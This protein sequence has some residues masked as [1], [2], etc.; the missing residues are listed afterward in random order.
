MSTAPKKSGKA[1]VPKRKIAVD[2]EYEVP[3]GLE[4]ERDDE[5][6]ESP[7]EDS[8]AKALFLAKYKQPKQATRTIK[9]GG[10][11]VPTVTV[12][13]V[14][15]R[16]KNVMAPGKKAGSTVPKIQCTIHV[17]KVRHNNAPDIV[18]SGV[19]GFD[20][21]LPTQKPIAAPSR[22][23]ADTDPEGGGK[24][25]D[26]K[27]EPAAPRTLALQ[28]GHKSIWLG[29]M[30]I[31]SFYTTSGEGKTKDGYEL[32]VPG[33]PV[34]VTGVMANVSNDGNALWLNATSCSPKLDGIV[35]GTATQIIM[36][37]LSKPD[38]AEAA[39]I[40]LSASMRGFYGMQLTPELE[41]QANFFRSKWS[42]AKDGAA[43]ACEARAMAIRA[44]SGADGEQH[45]GVLLKHAERLKATNPADLAFGG[46][47]FRPAQQ[48]T[49]DKPAFH[50]PIIVK[51]CHPAMPQHEWLANLFDRKGRESLPETFC[52]G[53]V[54]E[55]EVIGAMINVKLKLTWI[56]SKSAAI[57]AIAQGKDPT[58]DSGA[59]ACLGVKFN[60]RELPT[61][62]GTVAAAKAN[63]IC[64]HVLTFGDWVAVAGITPRDH[65]DTGVVC[66]FPSGYAVGMIPSIKRICAKV[67]E[68]YVLKELAG[69]AT[70]YVYDTDPDVPVLKDKE[71]NALTVAM[72]QLGAH[73]YQEITGSSFK[74]ALARMPAGKPSK[75][76]Y[77]WWKESPELIADDPDIACEIEAGKKAVLAAAAAKGTS[78]ATGK[79]LTINEFLMTYGLIY[80]VATE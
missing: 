65:T 23:A 20:W 27:K 37:H 43:A 8:G 74:F 26:K 41:V 57:A 62:T 28:E 61:V 58:L 4:D 2:P 34:E 11:S 24:K 67:D 51:G 80:V 52:V 55:T 47:F 70:Q 78:A 48:V 79:S 68:A 56:G 21:L 18:V 63:D 45:A 30:G 64:P 44:E 59:F 16:T 12:D 25:D 35:P 69:G 19:P 38:I 3:E 33:M 17:T 50:A 54:V 1:A 10:A 46:E 77:V 15:L 31:V 72:P 13:G 73:G 71:G 39:A 75:E 76:Y 49:P 36:D 42:G 7:D 66:V 9:T 40:H 5:G 32:I 6:N 29:H 22:D 53:E 14:V 60:M